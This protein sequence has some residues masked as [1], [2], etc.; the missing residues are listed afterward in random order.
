MK[1]LLLGSIGVIAE[2]SDIQRRAYN[3][4]LAEAVVSWHWDRDTYAELLKAA[5]GRYR[6]QQLSEAEG[7]CLSQIQIESIH[8][9]KT[10]IACAEVRQGVELRPGIAELINTAMSRNVD[11]ALVTSTYRP[12]IDA[13]I[14]GAIGALSLDQFATIVTRDDVLNGKPAPD[15][16]LTALERL[17]VHASEAVAIEDSEA[18]LTSARAARIYTIVTPGQFTRGQD[19]RAANLVLESAAGLSTRLF[20]GV[21]A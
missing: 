2:T 21:A 11:V 13:I 3:Q 17:G 12:N 10:E 20:T 14:D 9:R 1:A 16:Y 19:F 4:A 7:G 18:S 6:L 15:A 8:A 5:G